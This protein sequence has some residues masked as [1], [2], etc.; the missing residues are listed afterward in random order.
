MDLS[1]NIKENYGRE[2]FAG[3]WSSCEKGSRCQQV[4]FVRFVKVRRQ[5]VQNAGFVLAFA[6]FYLGQVKFC[7][8]WTFLNL[9]NMQ[10]GLCF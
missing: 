10:L 2:S 4:S 6:P 1:S 8:L 5:D 3:K 7:R 9:R